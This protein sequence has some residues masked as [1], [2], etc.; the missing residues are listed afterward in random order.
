MSE[1]E[2]SVIGRV[3]IARDELHLNVAGMSRV[4][5]L[6]WAASGKLIVVKRLLPH[7]AGKTH[8]ELTARSDIAKYSFGDCRTSFDAR[9]PNLHDCGDM[10]SGPVKHE[11][12]AGE[13]E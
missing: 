10:L 13:D 1:G 3:E 11:R 4:G 7:S 6:D 2:E 5:V 8:S 9:V 12:A